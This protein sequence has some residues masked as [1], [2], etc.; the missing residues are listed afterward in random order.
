MTIKIV[1]FRPVNQEYLNMKTIYNACI[2][3]N[4]E[5]PDEVKLFFEDKPPPIE[6]KAIE[7]DMSPGKLH[8]VSNHKDNSMI[9]DLDQLPFGISIILISEEH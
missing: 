1:G 3:A 5:V 2:K 4:I 8:G 6:D 9:I 7:V